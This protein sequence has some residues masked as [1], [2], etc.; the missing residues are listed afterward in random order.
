ML[1]VLEF[2]SKIVRYIFAQD[3]NTDKM[4]HRQSKLK[5]LNRE[6]YELS[7]NYEICVI[8]MID[9]AWVIVCHGAKA[10]ASRVALG[11]LPPL[12]AQLWG[13]SSIRKLELMFENFSVYGYD[14]RN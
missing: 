9:R 13:L 7:R 2:I 4:L 6:I 10:T 11:Y 5:Y 3:L 14:S 1:E 8:L 12:H